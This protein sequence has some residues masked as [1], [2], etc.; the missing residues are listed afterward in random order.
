MLGEKHWWLNS[1]PSFLQEDE[2]PFLG[3]TQDTLANLKENTDQLYPLMRTAAE[4]AGQIALRLTHDH[5][6]FLDLVGYTEEL[7]SFQN[8]LSHFSSDVKVR[9]TLE[10][11]KSLMIMGP[12]ANKAPCQWMQQD[13]HI[14]PLV[15]KG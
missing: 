5:E 10:F 13:G 3:T 7:K 1:I 11:T 4:V 9:R 2:Y 12:C 15:I 14:S 6:L 8:K